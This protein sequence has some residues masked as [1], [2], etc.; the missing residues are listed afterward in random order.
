MTLP[1]QD[2]QAQD[3]RADD[4]EKNF[5]NLEAKYKRELE[6][7]RNARLEAE[8]Q[9]QEALSRKAVAHDDDEEDDEPYVDKKKLDKKLAKFGEQNK[10]DTRSEIQ[11]AVQ[12]AIQQERRD[13]W[14]K[15]NPDF[16]EIFT[17]DNLNKFATHD[18][19]LAESI[20][21]MPDGFEKQK[22]VYRNIK[23]LGLHKPPV[24]QSTIQEKID[25]NRRS[26]YYQNP[27][28]GTAP[29]STQ[30]DFS[31]QGQKQAYEKM[32]ALKSSLRL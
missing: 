2:V 20:M 9:A 18:P 15:S 1:Q 3:P 22:L 23:A 6:Q 21:A 26:P 16:Q 13:N 12:Q 8:R 28:V 7:E 4:K 10:Q 31:P 29:Y 32:Q 19:E 14:L 17:E 25:A 5:R 30:S 24:K 11:K 27:S